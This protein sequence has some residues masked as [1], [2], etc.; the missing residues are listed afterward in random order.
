[1]TLKLFELRDRATFIPIFAFRC[2]PTSYREGGV[3]ITTPPDF[4]SHARYTAERYLLRRCGYIEG[5]QIMLGR[6]DAEDAR[7]SEC[8][9]DPYGHS[10]PRTFTVAHEYIEANW[11]KLE[12]GAVIDVEFILHETKEAKVSERVAHP[13]A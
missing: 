8:S 13:E 12:S 4:P 10:N 5:D 3:D 9:C 1:M 6:L 2:R 11:D 7:F